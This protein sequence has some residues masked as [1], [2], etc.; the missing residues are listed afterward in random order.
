MEVII[1]KQSTFPPSWVRSRA[2]L[3]HATRP[4]HEEL[5]EQLDW[6]KQNLA[7]A[8]IRMNRQHVRRNNVLV[9]MKLLCEPQDA[10]LYKL[11]WHKP[12]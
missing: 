8:D 11:R 5:K 7:S 9:S 4:W 1:L 6:I 10:L 12:T 3:E 2:D